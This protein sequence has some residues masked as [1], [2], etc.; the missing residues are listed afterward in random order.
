MLFWSLLIIGGLFA[1]L[2]I[3]KGLYAMFATL[4]CLMFSVYIAVLA[5]PR[6]MRLSHGLEK[7]PNY[8]AGCV[9]GMFLV[10][11]ILLWS[12]AW[13]FFLRDGEDY[14]PAMP[15][16]IGGGVCGFL[17]GYILTSLILLTV[18]IMPFS[19][20]EKIPGVCNR[21]AAM[22]FSVPAVVKTCN[23]I[24]EYSLECFDGNAESI[25][26]FLMSLDG[27]SAHTTDPAPKPDHGRF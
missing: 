14:F 24:A 7:D 6:I 11:F 10:M 12:I 27:R 5:A 19:R 26:D 23:F 22:R 18:C 9:F 3:K 2:G 8:A 17:F 13:F 1:W 16:R 20:D 25:V 4:F 21:Q 15:D